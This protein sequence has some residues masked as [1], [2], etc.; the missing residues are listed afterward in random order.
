MQ[1]AAPTPVRGRWAVGAVPDPEPCLSRGFDLTE[2]RSRDAAISSGRV[3]ADLARLNRALA[4]NL[5]FGVASPNSVVGEVSARRSGRR[6]E[7]GPAEAGILEMELSGG[8]TRRAIHLIAANSPHRR[9]LHLLAACLAECAM[10]L[11][12]GTGIY[13]TERAAASLRG[14]GAPPESP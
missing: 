11:G 4:V 8:A 7:E 12:L 3:A 14:A 5:R 13:R 10:E 9:H 1:A 6:A 2:V